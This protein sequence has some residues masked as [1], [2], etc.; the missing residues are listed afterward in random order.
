MIVIQSENKE[1]MTLL[2]KNP[3]S[4]EGYYR[5]QIKSGV[6]TGKVVDANTYMAIYQDDDH[7]SY[8][9]DQSNQ[10]D[11][12]NRCH[13][14]MYLDIMNNLFGHFAKLKSEYMATVPSWIG[15]PVSEIDN[16]PCRITLRAL[17]CDSSLVNENVNILDQM[18]ENVTFTY[19]QGNVHT[20]VIEDHNV[21]NAMTLTYIILH[22]ICC[23]NK[24]PYYVEDNL[25]QKYLRVMHNY[26][27][28]P[29]D[30]VYHYV[31]R[32]IRSINTFNEFQKQLEYL[33]E[34]PARIGYGDNKSRVANAAFN[35]IKP[36]SNHVVDFSN[37]VT[38]AKKLL[39]RMPDSFIYYMVGELTDRDLTKIKERHPNKFIKHVSLEEVPADIRATLVF[40]TE[41]PIRGGIQH[42]QNINDVFIC[43]PNSEFQPYLL[44]PNP[45]SVDSYSMR[46]LI[47]DVLPWS[48]FE[49]YQKGVGNEVNFVNA[50]KSY[51]AIAKPKAT[52]WNHT[53]PLLDFEKQLKIIVDHGFKPIGVSQIMFEDTFVFETPEEA[54]EAAN[55]LEFGAM[56]VLQGWWY[57]REHYEEAVKLYENENNTKVKTYWL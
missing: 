7:S 44:N 18:F 37:D 23:T 43:L 40:T 36:I 9:E 56:T 28:M 29:Y 49:T 13:P 50:Y 51:Y 32:V 10:I 46:R 6:I 47:D 4:N 55:T 48:D 45:T 20:V 41:Q 35:L 39:G 38:I 22:F 25:I 24:Q 12:L 15:K 21:F 5:T 57:G 19:K 2:N 26:G 1:L 17:Y 16:R 34:Y 8:A 11:F 27:N 30:F 54:V 42:F 52:G 33:L 3:S 14:A 53:R 31:N